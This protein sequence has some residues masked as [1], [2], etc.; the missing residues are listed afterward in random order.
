ME[1][2]CQYELLLLA[3]NHVA[4]FIT[5]QLFNYEFSVQLQ[6]LW[7]KSLQVS[8]TLPEGQINR[9]LLHVLGDNSIN[10]LRTMNQLRN[11]CLSVLASC[12]NWWAYY[13]PFSKLE[14]I[15]LPES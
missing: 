5:A 4:M 7:T 8:W 14:R 11:Y 10:N 12:Q 15:S 6:C 2:V 13:R 9:Q 1:L 3:V